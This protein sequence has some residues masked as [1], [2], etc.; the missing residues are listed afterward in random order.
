MAHWSTP[1]SE[2]RGMSCHGMI[3]VMARLLSHH[4][5][6]NG[7]YVVTGGLFSVHATA[8]HACHI[9]Q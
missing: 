7:M 4:G 3:A 5:C 2:Y 6:C 9:M 1:H 8:C